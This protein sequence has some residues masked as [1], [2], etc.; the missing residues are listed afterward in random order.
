MKALLKEGTVKRAGRG[1]P[2]VQKDELNRELWLELG[3][4]KESLRPLEED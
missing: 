1:H 3:E 4:T 2:H